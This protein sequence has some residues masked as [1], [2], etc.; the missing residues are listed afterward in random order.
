MST[1]SILKEI[2]AK[3]KKRLLTQKA[4]TSLEEMTALAQKAQS[5]PSFAE[6]LKKDGLS[7][8]GEIKKASPSKGMIK[9]DFDP[10]ALA[11][12]YEKCVDALSVLTEE[13][14][15]L[16]SPNYLSDV[17]EA[18]SLPILRKDFIFD[19]YQIYEA[20][21]LGASAVLLIAAILSEAQMRAMLEHARLLDMDAL[22]ETHSTEELEAALNAG[23]QIIGINNRDLN[24]FD[25]DLRTTIDIAKAVPKGKIIVSESG[26]HTAGDIKLIRKA[27]IDAVLV[28]ESFM[29]SADMKCKSR[30]FKDA[31]ED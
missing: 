25:V 30:E 29:K 10:V 4:E 27:E 21:A 22:V 15:F 13:D 9:D 2:V 5:R 31:Y 1:P 11:K 24:T 12:E 26:F 3:K 6:A 7:I 19:E 14:Y 23:A 16:G 17:A 28:G 20:K 8:I 18:V